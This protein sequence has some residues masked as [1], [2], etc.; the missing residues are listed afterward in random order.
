[1]SVHYESKY[2][3][4]PYYH[5]HENNRICC[6]GTNDTNTLNLVFGDTNSMKAY[7]KRYCNDLERCKR[8]MIYQALDRKYKEQEGG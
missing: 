4:C 7:S 1:M 3:A 6:E 2:A 5:R 8:C